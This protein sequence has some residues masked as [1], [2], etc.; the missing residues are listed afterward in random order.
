M[1]SKENFHTV[2]ILAGERLNLLAGSN[3]HG[4]ISGQLLQLYFKGIRKHLFSANVDKVLRI[5]V[6]NYKEGN[7]NDF[8]TLCNQIIV[9]Y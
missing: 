3:L 6:R 8:N 4:Q 2:Q 9:K 5:N 7:S 1:N